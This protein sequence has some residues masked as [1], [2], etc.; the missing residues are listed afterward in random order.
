MI[1]SRAKTNMTKTKEREKAK[2][3]IYLISPKIS[4]K[5]FKK[6]WD[7]FPDTSGG[8]TGQAFIDG[9]FPY[10]MVREK[11]ILIY[12]D[13]LQADDPVIFALRLPKKRKIMLL[14]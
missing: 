10:R 7:A 13:I 8:P 5:H 9:R 14:T 12:I 1:L 6:I 3:P 11:S 4:W 2:S